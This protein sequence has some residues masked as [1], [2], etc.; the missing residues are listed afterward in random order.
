M[1]PLLLFIAVAFQQPEAAPPA[2]PTPA[3]RPAAAPARTQ[4]DSTISTITGIGT[5][6]AEMRS[7]HELYARAAYNGADGL[8][9]ER[10][11]MF[12]ASCRNVATAIAAGQRSICRSC[13]NRSQ[14][15]AV[16]QYRAYLPA[17]ERFARECDR[18]MRGLASR[19]TPAAKSSTL[20]QESRPIGNRMLQALHTYE[21]RVQTLRVAMGWVAAPTPT[22]RGGN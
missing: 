4:F 19:G 20:R 22:P 13:L 8:V 10:G 15:A 9:I 7:A 18:R 17:L 2:R 21:L 12:G 3:Q 14:Q 6:V 1:K 16:D 5:K 11:G